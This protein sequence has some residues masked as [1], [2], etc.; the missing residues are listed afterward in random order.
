MIFFWSLPTHAIT[1]IKMGLPYVSQKSLTQPLSSKRSAPHVL[2]LLWNVDHSTVQHQS[3]QLVLEGTLRLASILQHGPLCSLN[4]SRAVLS[5]V[6]LQKVD[7]GRIY[8]HSAQPPPHAHD[9]LGNPDVEHDGGRHPRCKH[10]DLCHRATTEA[11]TLALSAQHSAVKHFTL[12]A[13]VVAK[14]CG[15]SHAA[16]AY[17]AR[18]V[19]RSAQQLT[20]LGTARKN[21]CITPG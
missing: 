14:D 9:K 10:H 19:M 8:Q 12:Q 17:R 20:A 7:G 21:A 4:L 15:S 1:N 18:V 16:R 6:E 2:C 3:A 5:K 13:A 11:T